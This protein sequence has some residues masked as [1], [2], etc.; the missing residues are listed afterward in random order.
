M[1]GNMHIRTC[2]NIYTHTYKCAHTHTHAHTHAQTRIYTRT[3]A[4]TH[5]HTHKE[6]P[7][8]LWHMPLEHV[9]R[10]MPFSCAPSAWEGCTLL[11]APTASS[12][13]LR[14]APTQAVQ[15]PSPAILAK[16]Q[17]DP[18]TAAACSQGAS[19]TYSARAAARG[20]HVCEK[21]RPRWVLPWVWLQ[22]R[23]ALLPRV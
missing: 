7:Q 13:S 1:H 9:S 23:R 15:Q 12:Q 16:P 21:Q 17:P 14:P 11:E 8:R 4:R 6:Q 20:A 18:T 3:Y 10:G 22:G 2:T 5:A 19:R